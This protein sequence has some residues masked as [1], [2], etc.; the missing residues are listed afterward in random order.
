MPYHEPGNDD[1][2]HFFKTSYSGQQT[3]KVSRKKVQQHFMQNKLQENLNVL[4]FFKTGLA[5]QHKML[6][7]VKKL[8]R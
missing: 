2:R 3:F 6:M 4:Y 7:L 5:N 8:Q 1:I